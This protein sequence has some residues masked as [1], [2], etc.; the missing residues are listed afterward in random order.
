MN[1]FG[2][3]DSTIANLLHVKGRILSYFLYPLYK[4]QLNMDKIAINLEIPLT[5]QNYMNEC[6]S[7]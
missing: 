3:Y 7:E 1:I 2:L 6:E 5:L 4:Y